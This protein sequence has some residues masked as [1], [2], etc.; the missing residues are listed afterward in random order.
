MEKLETNSKPKKIKYVAIGD[1]FSAGYNTKFG[2][3]A[4]GKKTVEGRVVGLGYPS[5]LASL[6][7]NQTD[8]ELESFDNFSMCTSNVKFWDSLIENNHKMLLNQSEKLDFI[9]ALDWNSLN[10]FK[11]FFT[12]YFK[13]WNVENDDFKV[14]SEKIKEA[15]FIT[16]SLG[17]ND[18]I[19]NLPYDRFRQ[20]IESGNKEKEGWVEIVKNLDTLFSKLTLDLSNF[21]KKL[22]SITSAKIVLVSYVKPL[23]Y[24]DDIFNSF[25]PIYEEE[26]KTIIDYFLS[27]LNMSLNKASKQINEVNFVNVCD[28]I[29][30]K[31][32]ITFLAENIFSI[33]PTENGYKKVAFDL[34]TKL[35]LNSDELNELFKDK[36]F[37]KNHIENI[38]YWLSQSTNKKIFNLN[39]A[40]QQI[41]KEI[42]GVNKNNN[43][44]TISNIE[45]A[46]V[47]L[48]SPY[49]SILPF[50]ESFIWYSKE[51]VQVIIEGF[52]SSKFLRKRTK[53]PSLNEVY[54]F[55]NDEK[56]AKEFFISFFKNGKLE[57]FTF[58][59]QR[60]IIDEIH[61]GKKLDLQL[62]RSTFID[63]VKSRQSLTYDVFKQLFNAKVI[64]DNKDI[65]KNIID[66]F[67]KDATTTDIL[68]F[69]FD[70]KINQ[71]YLKIKTFVANMETFKELA[72]FI[73][74][75]IT[76][77]SYGYAKLKSFDELWKHWIAK[78]KYNIIYLFDKLF[79]E[80]INSENMNQTIDFII[81]NIT[82]LVRLKN[83]DEKVSKSLRNTIESIFYSLKENPA[84]LNRTF[85]KLLKKVQKINLYDV[86]LNKKPIK[87]IFSWKSFVDFR[88]IF[89]VTFKIYRKILKI[90]WIIRENKI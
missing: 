36:T 58:L 26:N 65:I 25:F 89:F 42:F 62:F 87:K 48:K 14:V 78:N 72:N 16:V 19:F 76:T 57:K 28:E 9:Q 67:I 24:F 44:L 47:D 11:N 8:L 30:W 7:Q 55:L 64:Q 34:F 33:W 90:K 6:I 1:D 35:T 17:F 60:T 3:F 21:L 29:F 77:Y 68:E 80:L 52:K 20:Y 2:F 13:N 15:N 23:I 74:D 10:P 56:N 84:Y 75:S 83:L 4:N 37:I 18:L 22:R 45:H 38:N 43:L 86:L 85:N 66:K 51:N 31:N 71:K 69:M 46:L 32:H 88:D 41:F 27:K 49:L 39:K 63:L 12:S 79:L 54:K 50:L 59:W 5:F 73:V 53:Y 61:R 40:P 81:E 82:S 70:L